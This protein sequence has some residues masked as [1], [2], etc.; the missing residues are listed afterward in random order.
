MVH[1]CI[2]ELRTYMCSPNKIYFWMNESVNQYDDDSGTPDLT[3]PLNSR[4]V[5]PTDIS[6]QMSFKD[7]KLTFWKLNYI[8]FLPKSSTNE[9]MANLSFHLAIPKTLKLSLISLF[10]SYLIF[11]VYMCMSVTTLEVGLASSYKVKHVHRSCFHIS[12]TLETTQ[13]SSNERLDKQSLDINAIK[14]YPEI[15]GK[16]LLMY[17]TTLRNLKNIMLS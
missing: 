5:S 16:K 8:S 10:L 15:K 17:A 6:T 13:I 1:V 2:Q 9:Q 14:Y 4:H 12:P 7:F 11:V 3:S